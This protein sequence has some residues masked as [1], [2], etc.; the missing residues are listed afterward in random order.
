MPRYC[1]R[2][3]EDVPG[4]VHRGD[5]LR[6][7]VV[8]PADPVRP[9]DVRHRVPA[10][11]VVERV[12]Q[13]GPDVLLEVRQVRVVE[14]LEQ[15][16]G[17]QVDDVRAREP[18]DQVEGD[19]A[20]GELRDRLVGGVVGRDLHL[21]AGEL[22]E[23]LDQARIEVVG[24]VVDPERAALVGDA[25]GDRLVVLGD[26]PGD[27]VVGAGQR[28]AARAG[29]LR[30]DEVRRAVAALAGADR[31]RRVLAAGEQ[32]ERADS[33]RSARCTLQQ[34]AAAHTRSVLWMIHRLPRFNLRP[35]REVK[36]VSGGTFG[37]GRRGRGRAP[38]APTRDARAAYDRS[39]AREAD[40]DQVAR[41]RRLPAR[42]QRRLRDVPRGVPGRALRAGARGRRRSRDFVLARVAINYRR[43]LIQARRHRR[44]RLRG[45]SRRQLERHPARGDPDARR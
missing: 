18:D 23:L 21:A 40:R 36:P 17:D 7:L 19:R 20:G 29:R 4:H 14:R 15:L 33:E 25:V 31:R 32:P 5:V 10:A 24:V 2:L 3:P 39:S 28:Q 26:R 1:S 22:L 13:L 37:T 9:D 42:E 8:A 45:R 11:A 27:G 6:D 41:R 30:D 35:D 38:L 34:P 16:L 12:L 44:R 43:E